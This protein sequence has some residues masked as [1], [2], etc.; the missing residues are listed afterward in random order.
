MPG[1]L[2]FAA[3]LALCAALAGPAHA[4]EKDQEESET[5]P[6]G[7]EAVPV[8]LG[9]RTGVRVYGEEF[10]SVLA[11]FG[12]ADA[13]EFRSNLAIRS[14]LPL[15]ESLVLRATLS[16]HASFFDYS[17]NENGLELELGG[18]DLFERLYGAQFGLGAVYRLPFQRTFFGV[19]PAW[20]L[21]TEGRASLAW[22]NGA[23][24]SDAVKGSGAFG[25][26]FEIDPT[27]ELALG[28]DVGST[29]DDDG[30][31]VSPV[32]GFRWRFCE[33]MRL[34]SRGTGL[35]FAVDLTPELEFQLRGSYESDR[36]RLDDGNPP[37]TD[38]TLRKREAPVLVALRWAPTP[39]WRL[40][41]GAG[42]VVHQEWKVE[43]DD[44]DGPSSK[45]KAGPS[46]LTWLRVEYRF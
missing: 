19:T 18:I 4:K 13:S 9:P 42:S 2:R 34:E 26:G 14:G 17:G 37:L 29:I 28:V 41:L 22:E 33:R 27:L 44:D 24:L 8:P 46:A 39:H 31:N 35:L 23:S 36:Y 43:S 6:P 40:A 32:F 12:P 11:D 45:V 25:V 7:Q 3:G 21:F 1:R 5:P 10:V 20:S 30:V 16:G 38:L 15:S